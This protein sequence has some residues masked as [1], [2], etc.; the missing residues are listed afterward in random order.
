M[1]KIAFLSALLFSILLV[2]CLPAAL[3][4]ATG[5]PR[6]FVSAAGSDT[7]NCTNVATPCRHLEAYAV[8]A[9][10]GEIFVL[11][12]ANYGSL[13][14]TGPVSIQGHGWASIA[15]PNGGN[16]IT[17]N[18][19][20]SDNIS[21]HGV[22]IDGTGVTGGTN[23]IVFNSGG[24]FT[25]SDCVVQNFSGDGSSGNGILIQPASGSISFTIT[26]TIV[27]NN[28][29]VGINYGPLSGSA[30]AHGVIDHVVGT[31]NLFWGDDQYS[32]GRRIDNSRHVER[33]RQQQLQRWNLAWKCIRR[34]C[35]HDRQHQQQ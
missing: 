4:Q 9:Q 2:C 23:G 32:V 25:V 13:T 24:S 1:T 30:T 33:Y 8:T 11:D 3:A 12:P 16:A 7:N 28:V 22:A 18:A 31:N 21:I 15:P 27:S 35:G 5:A 6:T 26:D 20:S 14:I 29:Y 10:G 34:A 19:Q 17:I